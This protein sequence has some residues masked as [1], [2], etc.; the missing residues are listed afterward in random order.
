MNILVI[1][2]QRG[3]RTRLRSILRTLGDAPWSALFGLTVV[4]LYILAAILGPW[5]APF[6]ET[7]IVSD[8][9]FAPWSPEIYLGTDQQGRDTH[10]PPLFGARNTNRISLATVVLSFVVGVSL[11]L[12]AA[13]KA[14]WVDSF[15][16]SLADALMAIPPL[17]FALILISIAGSSLGSL[18][19]A[20]AAV[21][22]TRIFRL[23]RSLSVNVL[24]MD[25]VE[26]AQLRG[27][28]LRW[29]MLREILPN[30]LPMLVAEFGLRFCFVFLSISALAF[31]GLGIQPPTADWGSMVR[32]SAILITYSDITP[33][34]PAAAICLLTVAVNFL[35]DWFLQ[36]DSGLTHE[37]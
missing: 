3:T 24:A 31:L 6:G 30:I 12:M 10:S 8:I 15:L 21:D 35:V 18:I 23:T 25:F 26:V 1:W 13:V 9:P 20:I 22:I 33:L 28:R 5:L 27:E 14:G 37:S 16:L 34:I 4:A 29:L 36:Q 11:G 7:E 19:I 17:N 2:N 32:D